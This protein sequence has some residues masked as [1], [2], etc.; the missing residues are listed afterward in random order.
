MRK[1]AMLFAMLTASATLF[2][3][4]AA[5]QPV[6]N[7]TTPAESTTGY[8]LEDTLIWE[9]PTR[10]SPPIGLCVRHE[11][12]TAFCYHELSVDMWIKIRTAHT[13]VGYASADKLYVDDWRKLGQC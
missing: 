11:P 6:E 8:C 4:A 9:R 2:P 10:R 3:A 13:S 12:I 1:T 5:A 7:T